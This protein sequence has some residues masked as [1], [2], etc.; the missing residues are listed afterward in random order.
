MIVHDGIVDR[1]ADSID[2]YPAWLRERE[3]NKEK[4]ETV[5]RPAASKQINK[6][7]Q[8]QQQ[9]E[10][11][12]RL[13]PLYDIVKRI[14]DELGTCRSALSTVE[15]SL[16][17]ETLYVDAGRKDELQALVR[18]QAQTKAKIDTLEWEW[19]EASEKLEQATQLDEQT[20]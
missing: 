20:S 19:L 15:A 11:R 6:K 9:A 12:K 16:A 13:K 7:Q 3:E 8:R 18:E 1:F 4:L 14:D 10:Q 2:D 5:A 17:D